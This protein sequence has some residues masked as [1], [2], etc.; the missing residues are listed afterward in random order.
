MRAPPE[1]RYAKTADGVHIAYQTVGEGPPDIVYANSFTGHIEVSWEYARAARFYERMAAFC[2]L[3][4]FDRRGTGL[5]DPIVG[6]FMS[7]Q[8]AEDIEAV[9]DAVGIDRAVL[10]GSSEGAGAIVYFA[11]VHPERVAALVLFSPAGIVP[12]SAVDYPGVWSRE[13]MNEMLGSIEEAWG[14]S[15]L[16]ELMAV[17]NPSLRGDT[18]AMEWYARY[19]RLSASPALMRTLMRTNALMDLRDFLPSIQAP[20]LVIH[21][22]DEQ[23]VSVG[24]ARYAAEQIP[25]ARIVELPGTDHFIWEENA[26]VV[27]GEIE[28]F[29]TGARRA[30]D[31]VRGLKTLLFTDIVGSTEHARELGDERWRALLARHD[32]LLERQVERFNGHVVRTA[33]DGAF[34]TFDGPGTGIRCALAIREALRGL[35]LEIRAGVHTGEVELLGDDLGGIGVHIA[36][37]VSAAADAGQVLV[38]RTVADLIAGS[39]IRLV[40][41]GEH[42]LKGI[43]ERWRLY[44]ADI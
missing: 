6:S 39:D 37:R 3:V 17:V 11:A 19:F 31:S 15:S 34:A 29:V 38:S 25:G 28:E 20:T 40:D 36:A 27:V 13:F 1:T 22:K 42:D 35:G 41:Q 9:I 10:L 16:S 23:W 7:E 24:Y 8:R 43:S 18:A 21:R 26:D 30:H 44:L 32:A 5:S 14:S 33:G 12:P 2:R 4:L